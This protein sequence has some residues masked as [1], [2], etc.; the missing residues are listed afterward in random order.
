MSSTV[1]SNFQKNRPGHCQLRSQSK[2][3]VEFENLCLESADM[4][5]EDWISE[6]MSTKVSGIR[7]DNFLKF[8][9]FNIKNSCIWMSPQHLT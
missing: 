7:R 2:L 3:T 9:L 6:Y 4:V 5:S 1:S 8:W